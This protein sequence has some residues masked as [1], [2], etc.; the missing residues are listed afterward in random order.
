MW[1]RREMK[2]MIEKVS[3][4]SK[5]NSNVPRYTLTG[6]GTREYD[7]YL[8]MMFDDITECDIH[9]GGQNCDWQL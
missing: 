2:K 7:K 4:F 1:E 3:S 5:E 6:K 9:F 8:D